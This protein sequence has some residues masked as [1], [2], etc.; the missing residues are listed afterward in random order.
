MTTLSFI[1]MQL[2]SLK[3]LNLTDSLVG[4]NYEILFKS[5][6]YCTNLE[7]L[8]LKNCYL[9]Q[10]SLQLLSDYLIHL[11]KLETLSLECI[12]ISIYLNMNRE[13]LQ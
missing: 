10:R 9:D 3:Y 8:K 13:F 1:L 4:I 6:V 2:R 11:P 12:F 7:C 5:F